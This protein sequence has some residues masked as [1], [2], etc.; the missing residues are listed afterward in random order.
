MSSLYQRHASSIVSE[1][2]AYFPAVL[3]EGARQVGKSTMARA[4]FKDG[5]SKYLTLDDEATRDAA[6]ADPAGFVDSF[7]EGTLIIDEIQR[8]PELTL[9]I[10][11]SID[12]DRR[13]GR[14][15]LT[16]SSS[17]L[18]VR[19]TQDS[20][21]GRVSRIA[22]M[23]LSRGELDGI[24]EDFAAVATTPGIPD[25]FP[26]FT[27]KMTRS[28]YIDF[29]AAGSY[30]EALGLPPR[31]ANQWRDNYLD[32][33]VR[34][35]LPEL[36][37]SVSSERVFSILR[38][39]AGAQSNELVRSRLAADSGIPAST[40]ASYLDLINDVQLYG[41]LSPWTPNLRAREVNRPKIV[42]FDS[43]LAMRLSR[44]AGEQ[45]QNLNYQE[46]FGQFLE[47]FVVA[48]LLKQKTW[49]DR[50]FE[51]FHYRDRNG[52]EVDIILEFDDGRVLAL[53]IKASTSFNSR[54]FQ[55]LAALRDDLGDRFI[56]GIVLN[57]GAEGYRYAQKLWGLPISAL[58][59][60]GFLA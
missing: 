56:G 59:Q 21:A 51:L 52:L 35:D 14:F 41:T 40:V 4:M 31:M 25:K 8:L 34:R 50:D 46:A 47:G 60:G 11:A 17:L 37:K 43:G 9:A 26:A 15:L 18:R 54:Q 20:L 3:I 39:L 27:S 16:G 42:V 58:W 49:S 23:G 5:E 38:L 22:M 13:P 55:G 36:Q 12:R 30:P 10:K 1:H 33:I 32:S 6:I 48:E 29:C 53:E 57:T 45:L 44:I 2:L 19:G 7:A 24:R 28:D